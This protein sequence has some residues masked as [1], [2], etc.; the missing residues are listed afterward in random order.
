MFRLRETHDVLGGASLSLLIHPRE[1][2]LGLHFFELAHDVSDL[3]HHGDRNQVIGDNFAM[4]VAHSGPTPHSQI[5]SGPHTGLLEL[6][7]AYELSGLVATLLDASQSRYLSSHPLLLLSKR[8]HNAA[9]KRFLAEISL[10][11]SQGSWYLF[12]HYQNLLALV[13]LRTCF[14]L[15]IYEVL[16]LTALDPS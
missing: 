4:I 7:V 11:R 1:L 15:Q 5:L 9:A 2:N 6:E 16:L 10:I 3:L 8:I 12:C 14:F 13:R